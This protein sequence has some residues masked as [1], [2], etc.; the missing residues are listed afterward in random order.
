MTPERQLRV[1]QIVCI[2]FVAACTAI[3]HSILLQS[4]HAP[5]WELCL[6]VVLALWS[7]TSG[8]R[9]QRMLT[10]VGNRPIPAGSRSTPVSRWKA[11][12]A[13][14]LATATS[15]G[16]WAMVL[17]VLGGSAFL[18]YLLIGIALA[19]LLYWNPGPTPDSTPLES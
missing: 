15:V 12:H 14:R 9:V 11:G 6:L 13:I 16:L 17:Q 2:V 5:A 19:L 8:F 3:T 18:V 10:R 4:Q 1:F 7:A